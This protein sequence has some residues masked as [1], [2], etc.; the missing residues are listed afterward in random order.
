ME[1]AP[2]ERPRTAGDLA[3]LLTWTLA[4]LVGLGLGSEFLVRRHP[5]EDWP[6]PSLDSGLREV[7]RKVQAFERYLGEREVSR[8]CVFLGSSAIARGVSPELVDRAFYRHTGERLDCY[9]FGI[10]GLDTETA[11]HLAEVL[12]AKHRLDL[13]VLGL[14]PRDVVRDLP[15]DEVLRQGSW[16]RHHTGKLALKGWLIERSI[17]FRYLLWLAEWLEPRPEKPR[18][19]IIGPSLTATGQMQIRPAYADAPPRPLVLAFS[20]FDRQ[21]GAWQGRLEGLFDDLATKR[22]EN[23]RPI[24][25]VFEMPP[26]TLDGIADSERHHAAFLD[27]LERVTAAAGVELVPLSEAL[28][29]PAEVWADYGH[30]NRRGAGRF[31]AWLGRNLGRRAAS[32]GLL[33][34]GG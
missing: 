13:L 33:E 14:N 9:N 18:P 29:L 3:A 2:E 5:G 31:S 32:L 25:V 15:M 16:Y 7:D 30:L 10:R 34:D 20:D 27:T 21:L 19:Q 26:R 22:A 28:D 23:G 11:V 24:V 6:L 1:R 17:A 4:L 12:A 8:R